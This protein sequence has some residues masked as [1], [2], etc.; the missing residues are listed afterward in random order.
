MSPRV[1]CRP[2]VGIAFAR[3]SVPSAAVAG[4][5]DAGLRGPDPA[6][7]T[8]L[9]GIAGWWTGRGW[10]G[11]TSHIWR[12]VGDG[13]RGGDVWNR[14]L[15]VAV[16][17]KTAGAPAPQSSRRRAPAPAGKPPVYSP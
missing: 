11:S 9:P 12:H 13:K 14:R 2:I 17:G 16:E 5:P 15:D 4:L 1:S 3:I 7:A 10:G 6:V 8:T